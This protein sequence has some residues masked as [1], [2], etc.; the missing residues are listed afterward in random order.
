MNDDEKQRNLSYL[1][2]AY[3]EV[4]PKLLGY[5]VHLARQDNTAQEVVDEV[6]T[7]MRGLM[8]K[9]V[10]EKRTSTSPLFKAELGRVLNGIISD[11]MPRITKEALAMLG[12]A[13]IT[14]L[15]SAKFSAT[16]KTLPSQENKTPVPAAS[17]KAPVQK[18]DTGPEEALA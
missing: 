14:D 16:V 12:T 7:L 8:V 9:K 3:K 11:L 1:L 17:S 10:M 15:P 18:E 6:T 2:D 4:K 5:F 13:A